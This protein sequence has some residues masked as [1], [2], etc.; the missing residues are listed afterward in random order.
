MRL[1]HTADWH[2]GRTLEGRSRQEEQEAV[3]DEICRIADEE[4]IDAVL[5][6]GDVFDSVNPPAVS[7]TLFYETMKKLSAGARRPVVVISGNHDSPERVEA[8][9]PLATEHGI[10]LIGHPVE[11]PIKIFVPSSDQTMIV[12]AIPYPSESRLNEA[13]S[14]MNEEGH[15]RE[16]YDQRLA[17]LFA[18]QAAAFRSDMV[19]VAMSHLFVAGGKESDSERPIQVGGAYTVSPKTLSIGAQY[20]AL[21]HLHRPQTLKGTDAP[22]RYAGSPLAYSFS[23]AN[24]P[25]SVTIIDV[26]PGK[27]ANVQEIYLSAGRPLVKWRATGGLADVYQWFEEKRDLNAWIDLE[28]TLTDSLSIRDVQQL[29]RHRSGIVQI[30]PVFQTE[31]EAEATERLTDLPMETVFARFYHQQTGGAEPDQALVDLFLD[32]VKEVDEE[33]EDQIAAD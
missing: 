20:V 21:G 17:L 22:T 27:P 4:R 28:I 18:T 33:G 32:I 25:K 24:Q 10:T 13:L 19:N 5:M 26:E 14:E 3:M 16:A 9:A 11:H 6:A 7:E 1:L 31:K 29:R 8:A 23:E 30:R 2:L 15:I 12:S